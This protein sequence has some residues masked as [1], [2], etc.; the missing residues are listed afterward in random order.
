MVRLLNNVFTFRNALTC[1]YCVAYQARGGT[2]FPQQMMRTFRMHKRTAKV[3]RVC[4]SR[5]SR[6]FIFIMGSSFG[7]VGTCF[8]PEYRNPEVH[9]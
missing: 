1:L 7:I 2:N 6:Y 9:F 8:F 5:N 4:P 3:T